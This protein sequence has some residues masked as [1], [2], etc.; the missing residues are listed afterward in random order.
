MG[1][2]SS[3]GKVSDYYKKK[4]QKSHGEGAKRRKLSKQGKANRAEAARKAKGA[5]PANG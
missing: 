3:S 4:G 2:G 5:N 1:R